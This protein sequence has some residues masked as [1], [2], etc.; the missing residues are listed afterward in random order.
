METGLFSSDLK[1]LKALELNSEKDLFDYLGPRSTY[2]EGPLSIHYSSK[3]EK[4]VDY[5]GSVNTEKKA[6]GRGV[7]NR[8]AGHIRI[9]Y[10]NNG[11]GA[12]TGRYMMIYPAEGKI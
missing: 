6:T 7:I 11:S 2:Q 5:F 10:F 9:G 8:P 12:D 1:F 4:Y 3:Q